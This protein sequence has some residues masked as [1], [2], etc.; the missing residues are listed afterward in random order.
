[1][2]KAGQLFLARGEGIGESPAVGLPAGLFKEIDRRRRLGRSPRGRQVVGWGSSPVVRWGR[3]G[4]FL[5]RHLTAA[6]A[7]HLHFF[8]H[9]STFRRAAVKKVALRSGA[10]KTRILEVERIGVPR[11]QP[12]VG[13]KEPYDCV[14]GLPASFRVEVDE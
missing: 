9:L 3:G 14:H 11:A 7:R 6:P 4:G 1:R 12:A 2:P 10:R 5:F 13:S 8:H